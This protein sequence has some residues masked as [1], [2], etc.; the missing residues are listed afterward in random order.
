MVL[1]GFSGVVVVRT[2]L[3][4]KLLKPAVLMHVQDRIINHR[5]RVARSKVGWFLPSCFAI[6]DRR[7]NSSLQIIPSSHL[8]TF[9][10]LMPGVNSSARK[11]S[12][13]GTTASASIVPPR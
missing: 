11:T 12:T 4:G 5:M 13:A 2:V 9:D 6:P 8:P 10:F 7:S 1:G 3:P